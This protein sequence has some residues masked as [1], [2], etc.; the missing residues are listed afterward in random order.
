MTP[1]S[2]LELTYRRACRCGGSCYCM[3]ILAVRLIRVPANGLLLEPIGKAAPS[4]SFLRHCDRDL[5]ARVSSLPAAAYQS[6]Y[7]IFFALHR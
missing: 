3:Y 5:A 2:P 7:H 1:T 4:L 6:R